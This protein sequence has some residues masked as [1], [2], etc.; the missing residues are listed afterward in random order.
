MSLYRDDDVDFEIPISDLIPLIGVL[1]AP[2]YETPTSN[3]VLARYNKFSIYSVSQ[4]WWLSH[5]SNF[6]EKEKKFIERMQKMLA[7][8]LSTFTSQWTAKVYFREKGQ[9]IKDGNYQYRWTYPFIDFFAYIPV[10][11]TQMF[12]ALNDLSFSLPLHDLFPLHSRPFDIYALPSTKRPLR[13][14]R[15]IYGRKSPIYSCSSGFWSHTTETLTPQSRIPCSKLYSYFPFVRN[16]ITVN[17]K[18]ESVPTSVLKKLRPTQQAPL[19]RFWDRH[20]ALMTMVEKK[21]KVN[22]DL[23]LMKFL[24]ERN[25]IAHPQITQLTVPAGEQVGTQDLTMMHLPRRLTE[26]DDIWPH[27]SFGHYPL[28]LSESDV[29]ELAEMLNG[30]SSE[31]QSVRQSSSSLPKFL[32]VK[33]QSWSDRSRISVDVEDVWFGDV[34]MMTNYVFGGDYSDLPV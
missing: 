18:I 12:H 29:D 4:E 33:L 9:P 15:K 11:E 28:S 14:I 25:Y 8:S 31:I 16:V 3:E 30:I 32:K 24:T 19:H 22:F 26:E 23:Q 2:S 7:V 6:T 20:E 5:K 1:D 10:Y 27:E 34:K 13:L 17:V 21:F